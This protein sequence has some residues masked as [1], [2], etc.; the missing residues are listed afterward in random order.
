MNRRR[1]ITTLLT[2]LLLLCALPAVARLSA[3]EF[4]PAKV[5]VVR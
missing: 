2:A 3:L 1:V 4:G 5:L